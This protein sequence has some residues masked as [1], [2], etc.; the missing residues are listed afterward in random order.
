LILPPREP[1]EIEDSQAVQYGRDQN[2]HAIA[3][4]EGCQR[5]GRRADLRLMAVDDV[6]DYE[7]EDGLDAGSPPQAFPERSAIRTCALSSTINIFGMR[8]DLLPASD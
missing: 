2:P 5:V 7:A 3:V 1:H 8:P 6:R 4:V